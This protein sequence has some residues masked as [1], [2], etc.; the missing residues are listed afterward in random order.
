MMDRRRM[1]ASKGSKLSA[2]WRL[3]IQPTRMAIGMFRNTV[4][5]VALITWRMAELT[6]LSNA[7]LMAVKCSEA[8]SDRGMRIRP[9]KLQGASA[10]VNQKW[11]KTYTSLKRIS[12]LMI[13]TL[14]T[15]KKIIMPMQGRDIKVATN[16]SV[17]VSLSRRINVSDSVLPRSSSFRPSWNRL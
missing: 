14:S 10:E 7:S 9:M 1:P 2:R 8:F 17:R 4:C 11:C 5:T 15:R 6:R 3:V 16:A 13:L 12:S